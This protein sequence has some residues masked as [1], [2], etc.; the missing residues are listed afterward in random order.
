MDNIVDP[1][2]WLKTLPDPSVMAWSSD[3]QGCTRI[4]GIDILFLGS[5]VKSYIIRS[6]ASEES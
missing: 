4:S 6:K 3:I 5:V 2:C 1:V